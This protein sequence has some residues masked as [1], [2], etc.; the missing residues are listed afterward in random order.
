MVSPRGFSRIRKNDSGRNGTARDFSSQ[1]DSVKLE[2]I[3][4]SGSFINVKKE[5]AW[6]IKVVG[7]ADQ[8]RCLKQP[9]RNARRNAKFPLNL[10]K[11][12]RSIARIVFPNARTVVGRR[13]RISNGI[14]KGQKP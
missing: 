3:P 6:R 4:S 11:T 1:N 5:E 13:D 7:S 2:S 8:K 12:A 9:A 10:A 14:N